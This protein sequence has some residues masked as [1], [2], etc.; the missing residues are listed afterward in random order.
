MRLSELG[1]KEII[2]LYNGER[3]GVL[4]N[5]DLVIDETTGEII[6]L[7]IPKRRIPYLLFAERAKTE[8]T[9]NAIKK[10]G[11]DIVI[12][13]MEDHGHSKYNIFIKGK[14]YT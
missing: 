11:P 12:I 10:I 2:N 1:G 8:V 9:W 3:L 5:T 7:V 4:S 14:N 13:V 6:C